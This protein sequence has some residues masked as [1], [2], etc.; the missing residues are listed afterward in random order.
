MFDKWISPDSGKKLEIKEDVLSDG[1]LDFDIV[2]GI[3][4]FIYP[5][6]INEEDLFYE[7]IADDYDKYI[8]LTFQTYNE[9]EKEVRSN[10]I[11]LLELKEDFKVLELACG[12]GRDSVLIDQRLSGDAELHLTDISSDML[13]RAK[14]K[15]KKSNSRVYYCRSNAMYLPYPDNYFDAFYSF[16][17]VGE[18]S[19]KKKFFEEVIRVCKTGAKVVVGDESLPVWQRNTLFGKILSNYNKLFLADVPFKD[20]PVD[21]REVRCQWIIGGVFYLIDFRVGEGEPYAN[22]DFEIPGIRGGT[23]KTRYYG[24]LEGV[25]EETKKLAWQAREKAGLSMHKWLDDIVKKEA[26]KV[27]GS[28]K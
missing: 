28:K 11:D 2:D 27:L 6:S 15:L 26:L 10:M 9:D 3:P 17:A 21:A 7:G 23:H 14:Q 20:L 12:T 1:N 19:D 13:T 24:Q 18:F 22:F 16:G 5:Q 4:N 25:T 8:H